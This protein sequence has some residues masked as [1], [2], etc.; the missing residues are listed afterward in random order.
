METQSG[1]IN[2]PEGWKYFVVKGIKVFEGLEWREAIRF[3]APNT[4]NFSK[5][6]QAGRFYPLTPGERGV[7]KRDFI[8]I[9]SPKSRPTVYDEAIRWKR[10]NGHIEATPRGVL[11]LMQ[12]KPK[13]HHEINDSLG[14]RFLEQVLI[15][16]PLAFS[17]RK[18]KRNM[19]EDM[20]FFGVYNDEE[21]AAG[22]R[23]RDLRLYTGC[24]FAFYLLE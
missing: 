21:R 18:D 24:W 7:E 4:P 9:R 15:Y 23:P 3:G 16:S 17:L 10:K 14:H 22:L 20:M 5:V 8:L 2:P 19:G 13:L 11:S 12:Q 1:S 6:F